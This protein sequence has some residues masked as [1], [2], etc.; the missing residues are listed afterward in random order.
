MAIPDG[1]IILIAILGAAGGLMLCVAVHRSVRRADYIK[2]SFH[3]S[4][5][6]QEYM[7][8]VRTKGWGLGNANNV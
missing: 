5:E 1:V 2:P 8:M 7:R 6:Q 4:P 3:V